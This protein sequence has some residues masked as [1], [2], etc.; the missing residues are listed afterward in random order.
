MTHQNCCIFR[1]IIVRIKLPRAGR[2][3][4]GDFI[5][6]PV[7]P[8]ERNLYG[9]ALAR[10]VWERRFGNILLEEGKDGSVFL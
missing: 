2:P 9:D 5:E 1:E 3:H 6:D 7:V 10:L 8:Q 4:N